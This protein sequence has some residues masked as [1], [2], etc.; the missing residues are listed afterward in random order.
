MKARISLRTG[1]EPVTI[2]IEEGGFAYFGSSE[3]AEGFSPFYPVSCVDGYRRLALRDGRLYVGNGEGE[4]E[5]KIDA[6][7]T[8][9]PLAIKREGAK[10]SAIAIPAKVEIEDV[11]RGYEFPPITESDLIRAFGGFLS[12][13]DTKD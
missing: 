5:I 1:N 12:E 10:T 9:I 4:K 11:A 7:E 2:E 3:S 13:D 6:G 8:F